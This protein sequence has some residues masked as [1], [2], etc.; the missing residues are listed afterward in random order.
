MH[1]R[2]LCCCG[3]GSFHSGGCTGANPGVWPW[4]QKIIAR[5]P[6]LYPSATLALYTPFMMINVLLFLSVGL[7]MRW[8]FVV[9]FRGDANT[10]A[11]TW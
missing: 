9:V 4:Q 5:V 11:I 2:L 6:I 10:V 3:F 7:K 8:N 1:R